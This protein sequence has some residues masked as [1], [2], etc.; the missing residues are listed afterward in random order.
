M[1]DGGYKIRNQEAIH[2]ITF[3]VVGWIDVFTRTIYK[4]ILVDGLRYCQDQKGLTVHSW[5]IMTNHVHL[6]ISAK[7][8]H[9]LSNILRD[10]KKHTSVQVLRAIEENPSESRREWMLALFRE[11]GNGN[12]RNENRQFWRQDN[13]P[14]ELSNNVM[15]GQRL[16]YVHNNPV[17][18]GIVT[19][20]TDYLYS[21]AADYVGRKG[22][23]DVVLL[24]YIIFN[25][26]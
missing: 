9:G 13:H 1:S 5:V 25:Y 6:I 3:A 23:I 14:I 20:A 18:A 16:N 24:D 8:G 11:A 22:L 26:P 17:K 15:K 2:F 7:T 21:S 10:F 4:D 12:V 19:N